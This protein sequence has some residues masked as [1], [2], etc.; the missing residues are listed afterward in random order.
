MTL[1]NDNVVFV[2]VFENELH[3][4]NIQVEISHVIEKLTGKIVVSLQFLLSR[5]AIAFI[6][7]LIQKRFNGS[8]R[9]CLAAYEKFNGWKNKS[10]I[11]TQ[12]KIHQI[13]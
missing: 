1:H 10:A 11:K 2:F 5:N 3:K 4:T 8:M 9:S 7:R 13:P 6:V 12:H